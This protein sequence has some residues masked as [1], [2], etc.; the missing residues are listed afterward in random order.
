MNMQTIPVTA[1]LDIG[2]TN[3]K[4]LLFDETYR[5][6]FEHTERM[7]ETV[8]ED[9]FPCE[10]LIALRDSVRDM[11]DQVFQ[12]SQYE[13]KAINFTTY[14]ASFVYLDDSGNPLT[15]LYNY[16]KPYPE[17]LKHA[18]YSDYGGE[19][20]FLRVTSSPSLGSLNSGLQVLRLKKEQPA[21]FNLVAHALH[22]PQYISFLFTG[23][24][25]TDITSIGCHTQLWDFTKMSY[26]QWVEKEGLTTV[27]GPMEK[28]DLA[29]RI[30]WGN[31]DVWAGV[32]LHD[33]SS[34]LIPYLVSFKEPFILISTGTWS[35]S[36][37]PFDDIPL[38]DE[39]LQRDCLC[40]LQ[41]TGRPVK[42]ARY[43]L[44]PAHEEGVAIIAAHFALPS[45]FYTV[46][47]FHAD[48]FFKSKELLSNMT[49][50]AFGDIDLMTVGSPDMAYYLLMHCLVQFQSASTRLLLRHGKVEKILVDGG[51]SR[52]EIFM[53]MLAESFAEQDVY[54]SEVPQATAMGA[55]LV[56]HKYWNDKEIPQTII[57]LKAFPRQIAG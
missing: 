38:T 26:H 12:M 51:F 33:S 9:G 28:S 13:V 1:I 30:Q 35:I 53:Q 23:L 49:A 46:M 34:A 18:L 50:A 6:V 52:N 20:E 3:K 19:K 42:A 24:K 14:G 43:F 45:D 29:T 39:E 32:G 44:G 17:A 37:N 55:A 8:D 56:Q 47:Q 54:A 16:L 11:M 25:R 48:I 21:I 27:L 7:E 31:H 2:K 5:M 41:Y 36:L 22:L 15:H 57:D 40:Y 10:D 4:I